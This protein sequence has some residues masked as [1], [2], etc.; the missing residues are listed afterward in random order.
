[1]SAEFPYRVDI[2][3]AQEALFCPHGFY[4]DQCGTCSLL[5][6]DDY[7]CEPEDDEL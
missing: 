7:D 5:E 1:M 6:R 2:D 3:A 4:V